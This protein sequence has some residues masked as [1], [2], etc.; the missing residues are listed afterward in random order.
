ME[1]LNAEE[2][3]GLRALRSSDS[4]VADSY[5]QLQRVLESRAFRRVQENARNFLAFVVVQTLLGRERA[6]KETTIGARI[7]GEGAQASGRVRVAAAALRKRLAQYYGEEGRNDLIEIAIPEGAYVPKISDR[8]PSVALALF[9]NWNPN[10]EDAHVARILALEGEEQLARQ[11]LR[12]THAPSTPEELENA[13][14]GIRGS[15]FCIQ[16]RLQVNVCVTNFRAGVV[17][18]STTVE[19]TRERLMVVARR[20]AEFTSGAVRQQSRVPPSDTRGGA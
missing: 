3:E 10:A 20:V 7:Y 6:I 9:E 5:R 4:A 13:E 2:Q 18:A 17:I 1:F 11:G 15:Y 16:S 19:E 8:R 12:V 14:Y